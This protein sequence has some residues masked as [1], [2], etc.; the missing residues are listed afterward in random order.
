PLTKKW[1]LVLEYAFNKNTSVSHRNTYNK[2]FNG[3]YAVLDNEFSNN[4][5]LEAFS[6]SGSA[7]LR[8]TG[9]KL[10]AAFG[11]GTSSVQEN[12]FNIDSN[13]RSHYNFFKMT[14]QASFSYVF[15]PQTR[16]SLNYRGTTRQPTI[17][18]LQPI[19]DNSD[20]LNVFVGN[21]F[22]RVSFYHSIN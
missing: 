18:Q 4:F 11:T 14:P 7:I 20:R 21:P 2:D 9:K 19:R 1:N 22:L 17:D 15:A 3:K 10:R 8:Y 13:R 6:H 16:L 12:L 5:N